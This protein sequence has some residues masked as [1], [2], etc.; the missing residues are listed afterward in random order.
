MTPEIA[1]RTARTGDRAV[2]GQGREERVA[3]WQYGR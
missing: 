1:G 2:I 3:T